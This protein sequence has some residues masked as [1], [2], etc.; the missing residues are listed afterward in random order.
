MCFRN[1]RKI[2]CDVINRVSDSKIWGERK[3]TFNF[4][5][6]THM[7]THIYTFMHDI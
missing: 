1:C 3:N 4:A 5:L 2:A 7:H 6:P